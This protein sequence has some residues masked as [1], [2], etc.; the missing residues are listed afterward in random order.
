MAPFRNSI[1]N[2]IAEYNQAIGKKTSNE[3]IEM[4]AKIQ[5]LSADTFS[6]SLK[7]IS[8]M[9]SL[10][11]I[12]TSINEI[13]NDTDD[14]GVAC[15]LIRTY[16]Y[17]DNKKIS[18]SI[19]SKKMLGMKFNSSGEFMK[20]SLVVSK[21][22]SH[23]EAP[24]ETVAFAALYRFK[25]RLSFIATE[26]PSWR[27]DYTLTQQLQ[28]YGNSLGKAGIVRKEMFTGIKT[29]MLVPEI[30]PI[31]L[32]KTSNPGINQEI[33]VERISQEPIK[34][35]TEIDVAL[36][37]LWK[38]F[39]TS[40]KSDDPRTKLVH[41]IYE[42]ISSNIVQKKLTLKNILNAAKSMTKSSYYSEVYPPL[43]W[44]V[45][46][47]A[48]GERC[49]LYSSGETINLVYSS[50]EMVAVP[51]GILKNIADCELITTTSGK[52]LLGV[53]DIMNCNGQDLTRLTIEDR[54]VHAKTVLAQVAEPLKAIGVEVFIK[55]YIQISQ[56]IEEGILRVYN[57][58]RDYKI[59]GLILT[60]HTGNYYE[61]KNRKWKP[62]EENTIDFMVV[63]CPK[64][65]LGR[66]EIPSRPGYDVYV[67]MC[68]MNS[69]RRK[70]YGINLWPSYNEDTNVDQSQPYVPVL[71]QSALWPYS[72]VYYHKID[73]NMT[74]TNA[75]LDGKVCEFSVNI[76][77]AN[78]LKSAFS[79]GAIDTTSLNLWQLNRIRTDRSITAGEYGNDYDIAEQ[80]F[81]NIIDPFV[82]ED[83]WTGN[84]SYFEKQRDAMY[85]SPNKFKRFVIK[86]AFKKYLTPG[87][88]VLDIAAGRGADLGPYNQAGIGRLIAMDIDPTA[89]VELI[90]R[91]MDKHITDMRRGHGPMKLN[92]LVS[93]V[94][95]NSNVNKKA[96]AE[97]FAIDDVDIIVCNFAF[98]YFCTSAGAA[99]NALGFISSMCD[100]SHDT[101]F[102]MTV[103]DG[104]K[105]FDILRDVE[106]GQAWK[107][108]E[109]SLDKYLIRK[110]Y[111]GSN[112]EKYGQKISVKLPMTTKLYTEPLCN[113]EALSTD[114]VDYG[115]NLVSN[116]SFGEYLSKFNTAEPQVAAS[117]TRDDIVYC[118]MHNLV[119]FK[120]NASKQKKTKK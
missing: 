84:S 12:S 66:K 41:E 56:P 114:A 75:D 22:T 25:I 31:V 7:A 103:L 82:I 74:A 73:S 93:D 35:R 86:E 27:Y 98:H 23:K 106:E 6:D 15:S 10:V 108:V 61:T 94:S 53:F 36:N 47:K 24:K 99:G 44:Y 117:L 113:I 55:D 54:M 32:L 37:F 64:T 97:R 34:D 17:D 51:N 76:T 50:V 81:S 21:E 38:T 83:L 9:A 70:Q 57:T 58:K 77:A 89:L 110:D 49:V 62:T 43:G 105:V 3:N 91:S 100:P 46:D 16:S 20:Y 13:I 88:S 26:N 120:K 87:I 5:S 33:E 118:N 4:E 28:H 39:D 119:V 96:L 29:G 45:T 79:K 112:L 48:D 40:F 111:P 60:S 95:G 8:E 65:F 71:F 11:E 80:V 42:S 116:E 109:N 14:N 72:Y 85:R 78:T 18:E 92:V 63:K 30:L 52:R 102:I 115:L 67:L 104:S 59:D 101:Y 19:S 69:H 107:V 2:T 68:G 90:H 1:E